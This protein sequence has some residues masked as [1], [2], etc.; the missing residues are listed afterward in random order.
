MIVIHSYNEVKSRVTKEMA[1]SLFDLQSKD[2]KRLKIARFNDPNI[3]PYIY[4]KFRMHTGSS[5]IMMRCRNF[6]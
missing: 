5:L 2:K 3:A 1:L 6:L 4:E